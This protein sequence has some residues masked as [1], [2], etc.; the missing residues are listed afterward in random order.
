MTRVLFASLLVFVGVALATAGMFIVFG[1]G[2][3]LIVGGAALALAAA[4]LIDVE[5][6]PGAEPSQPRP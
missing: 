4:L 2:W 6:T 5:E 3:A 1:L